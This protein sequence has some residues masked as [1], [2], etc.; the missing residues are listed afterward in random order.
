MTNLTKT[1]PT[2]AL[3]G[4]TILPGMIVHFDVSRDRSKKAIEAAMLQ[5]QEVFLV[6]QKD[7]EVEM[8]GIGDLYQIG[9]TAYVK[10]VV[11]LPQNLI[12]VLVEGVGKGRLLGLEKEI[13]YLS[14]QI[15]LVEETEIPESPEPVKEAMYRSMRELFQ[16]YCME[17]GKI[18]K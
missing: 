5:E 17:N 13:P 2:I 16:R 18:S 1:I 12:R 11:K 9:T 3:R 15:S 7:P 14:G 6:T 8:P 4:T 10:Q